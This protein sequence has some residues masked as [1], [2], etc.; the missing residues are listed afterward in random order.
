L[1]DRWPGTRLP[2]VKSFPETIR[3]IWEL[4][5]AY[6]M[7]ELYQPLR[8]LPGYIGLGLIGAC[9]TVLGVGLILLGVL[10]LLQTEVLEARA[11]RGTSAWPYFIVCACCLLG[12]VVLYRRINRSFGGQ[13]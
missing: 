9:S 7:Q 12:M 10:R 2:A 8:G 11:D 13:S 6:A 4:V 3:E 5:R 1:R